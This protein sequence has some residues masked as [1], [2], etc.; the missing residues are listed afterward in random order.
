MI[1]FVICSE[2][3]ATCMPDDGSSLII[4]SST[5]KSFTEVQPFLSLSQ[6]A[7]VGMTHDDL[8]PLFEKNMYKNLYR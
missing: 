3:R 8:K 7:D 1:Y 2:A 4:G 6:Y 5:L